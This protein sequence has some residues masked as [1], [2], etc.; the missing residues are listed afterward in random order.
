MSAHNENNGRRGMIRPPG[1]INLS[2][3]FEDDDD[4]DLPPTQPPPRLLRA[5][6][7]MALYV[8]RPPS[9]PPAHSRGVTRSPLLQ[10]VL[11]NENPY[12]ILLPSYNDNFQR[13]MDRRLNFRTM[14]NENVQ[15]IYWRGRF[16]FPEGVTVR[17]IA[18][19]IL[20]EFRSHHAFGPDKLIRVH[21]W[22]IGNR[23][24]L[25][26][27]GGIPFIVEVEIAPFGPHEDEGP[28]QLLVDWIWNALYSL[29]AFRAD[30]GSERMDRFI[31]LP[32]EDDD[33]DPTNNRSFYNR[34]IAG[35][36]RN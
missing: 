9:P 7:G 1:E 25:S 21:A 19:R 34:V 14:A 23:N 10:H 4:D 11:R 16:K 24:V 35:M 27:E 26:E 31:R 30:I 6:P 17:M 36:K 20:G 29:L 8:P 2:D 13:L 32:L 28:T 22:P 12:D 3:D 15:K 5:D 18:E 33:D